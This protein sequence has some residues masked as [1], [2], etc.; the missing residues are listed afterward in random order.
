MVAF[1]QSVSPYRND[2]SFRKKLGSF[3]RASKQDA[4]FEDDF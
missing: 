1:P 3:R 2:T 4:I